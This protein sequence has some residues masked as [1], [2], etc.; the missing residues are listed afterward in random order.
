MLVKMEHVLMFV[1]VT[2]VLYQLMGMQRCG[3]SI[4]SGNNGFNVGANPEHYFPEVLG[5]SSDS[6]RCYYGCKGFTFEDNKC[7]PSMDYFNCNDIPPLKEPSLW[8]CEKD[9]FADDCVGSR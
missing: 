1:I 3:Y 7:P 8:R 2:F 5:M 9:I 6:G 4:R